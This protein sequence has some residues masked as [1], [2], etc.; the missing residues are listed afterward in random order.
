MDKNLNIVICDVYKHNDII[1]NMG[2]NKEL[3][4]EPDKHYFSWQKAYSGDIELINLIGEKLDAYTQIIKH[5][6]SAK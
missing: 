5:L 1:V 2:S 3:N 4:L 6:E